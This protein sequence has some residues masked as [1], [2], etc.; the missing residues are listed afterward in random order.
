MMVGL[1][2]IKPIENFTRYYYSIIIAINNN[3]FPFAICCHFY[4]CCLMS[5]DHFITLTIWS[6]LY[7]SS[8]N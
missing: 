8:S 1:N 5:N 6:R 4:Y 7:T 2:L 3:V